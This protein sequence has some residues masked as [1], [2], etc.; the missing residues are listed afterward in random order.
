MYCKYCGVQLPDDSAY[1]SKCGKATGLQGEGSSQIA[2]RQTEKDD[3]QFYGL[4]KIHL[5]LVV[6]LQ[7]VTLGIYTM[8]WFMRRREAINKLNSE[9][10]ISEGVLIVIA[11]F[12]AASLMFGIISGFL[13]VFDHDTNKLFEGLSN[14]AGLFSGIGSIVMAFKYRKILRDHCR[15]IR[16]DVRLEGFASGLWTFLF[17]I[18]YLQHKINGM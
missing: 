8:V 18:M 9:N 6:L 13:V 5:C 4:P 3:K 16:P 2:D 10:K 17:G 14:L 1:C 12:M 7:I 11:C 15:E